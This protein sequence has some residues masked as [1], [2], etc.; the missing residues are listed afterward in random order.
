MKYNLRRITARVEDQEGQEFLVDSVQRPGQTPFPFVMEPGNV[1]ERFSYP[2]W[3]G[4]PGDPPTI[5]VYELQADP[6]NGTLHYL[7]THAEILGRCPTCGSQLKCVKWG[8]DFAIFCYGQRGGDYCTY[9]AR[10]LW[11]RLS[12]RA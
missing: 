2:S 1:P 12:Q 7:R 8:A 5:E 4:W 3:F 11:D 10:L 6:L 9:S